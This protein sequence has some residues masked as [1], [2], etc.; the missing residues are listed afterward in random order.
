M[1]AGVK[2]CGGCNPRYDRAGE[3]ER[4]RAGFGNDE[5]ISGKEGIHSENIVFEFARQDGSYDVLLTICGCD[6]RCATTAEYDF[7]EK[8][9]IS[10][11]GSAHRAIEEIEQMLALQRE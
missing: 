11:G 9:C 10:S 7:K 3:F 4:I 5:G 6:N 1:R 2:F 8:I